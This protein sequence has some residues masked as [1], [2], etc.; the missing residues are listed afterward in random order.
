MSDRAK[1]K[2]V[3]RRWRNGEIVSL[4]VAVDEVEAVMLPAIDLDAIALGTF[5]VIDTLPPCN[6]PTQRKAEVQLLIIN[7]MKI[8]RGERP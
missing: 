4:E 7:A 1:I 8:A 2:D 3:L 5:N 6:H